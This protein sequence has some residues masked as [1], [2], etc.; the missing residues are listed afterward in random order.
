[1]SAPSFQEAVRAQPANLLEAA[2]ALRE[3]LA[4]TELS[5]LREGTV[6][7]S[8]IGASWHA[9]LPAVRRMR[10]AVAAGE[11][12]ILRP[13]SAKEIRASF[14]RMDSSLCPTSSNRPSESLAIS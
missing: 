7:F 2:A 6:V 9:L 1:M 5:P 4:A 12:P 10:S 8:G 14:C 11:S 3:A 13:N